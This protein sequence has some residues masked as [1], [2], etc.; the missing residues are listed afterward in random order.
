MKNL[1]LL[2][3]FSTFSLGS[4]AK[5]EFAEQAQE[6][7]KCDAVSRSS[8]SSQK[9]GKSRYEYKA[10]KAASKASIETECFKT[11]EALAKVGSRD[12]V[13]EA[14]ACVVTCGQYLETRTKS[15]IHW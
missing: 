2:C 15:G 13:R 7:G 1:L 8:K 12:A 9:I 4:F 14:S 6:I 10:D 5:S 3:F 11:C